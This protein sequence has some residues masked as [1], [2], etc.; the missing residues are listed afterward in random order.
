MPN[1]HFDCGNSNEGH[2]GF[3]ARVNAATPEEA[4]QKLK[5]RLPMEVEVKYHEVVP[6]MDPRSEYIQIYITP[7][8]ITVSDI[9]FEDADEEEE[10][11]AV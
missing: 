11:D 10:A 5:D 6:E 7:E 9:D 3:C 1:Y 8:N 4:L 2:I